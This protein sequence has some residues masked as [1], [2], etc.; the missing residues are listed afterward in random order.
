MRR[1]LAAV[2]AAAA[3]ALACAPG[4]AF[5]AA[6]A[7]L[8]ATAPAAPAGPTGIPL[9]T[10]VRDVDPL[11]NAISFGLRKDRLLTSVVPGPVANTEQLTVGIGPSGAPA[12]VT[13]LQ[14]LVI[15]KPGNYIVRELG[16]ARKAEG[17]DDTVPPVL[18][19]GQVVW[20]GFSPGTRTLRAR[21]T[22]DP[23]I[24]AHRLPMAVRLAFRD[25]KGRTRPLGPGGQAPADGTV[26]LTLVN[27]TGSPR[28]LTLGSAEPAPLG[29]A[30]DVLYRAAQA[31][32]AALP[33]Y[34]GDGL[35]AHL[36]GTSRGQEQLTVSAPLR[37][38]GH[39]DVAEA[40]A[41]A[42]AT[43]RGPGTTPTT[44][45][46]AVAGTLDGTADFEI[47]LRAGQHLQVDLDVRPWLDPRTLD[48]RTVVPPAATWRRWAANGPDA[49]ATQAATTTLAEAAAAAARAAEYS[50][51]LQADTPGTDLTSFRYVVA[52]AAATPRAGEEIRA[53]PA[54][55]AA[56][57]FALVAIAGNAALLWREL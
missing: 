23:G 6:A 7:P 29:D 16:P 40:A 13:D 9:L 48:P 53:K 39:L 34:A 38:T 20:Q 52:P 49:A 12:V 41:G 46:A 31:P 15:S 45:G 5:A 42:P 35:P 51:Y 37:V 14:Q 11:Q 22:L 19:L 8:P 43:V 55:I 3:G 4:A 54:A 57:G 47:D 18:E 2:G 27:A 33:P 44:T 32:R 36:P 10:P 24:E 56:A 50:P 28:T 21:L 1:A 30:L 25:R 26:R 17:L